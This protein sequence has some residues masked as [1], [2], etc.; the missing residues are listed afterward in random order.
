M[1]SNTVAVVANPVLH[2]L[3]HAIPAFGQPSLQVY[4]ALQPFLLMGE[5]EGGEV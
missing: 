3:I 2:L 4:G 5:R 1:L